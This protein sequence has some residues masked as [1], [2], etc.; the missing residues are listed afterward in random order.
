MATTKK[1][2]VT[3]GSDKK[4]TTTPKKFKEDSKTE[5]ELKQE[6]EMRSKAYQ[7]KL[8]NEAK[9]KLRREKAI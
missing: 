5:E 9:E 4:F 3:I 8:A 6:A 1:T 2:P 7:K